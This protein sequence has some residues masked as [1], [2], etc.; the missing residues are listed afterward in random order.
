[1]EA[2][3]NEEALLMAMFN[4][5]VTPRNT[6]F[7][8]WFWQQVTNPDLPPPEIVSID[9]DP[10]Y[11]EDDANFLKTVRKDGRIS[12]KVKKG[13]REA[14]AI[15]AIIKAICKVTS[16]SRLEL[17]Y[18]SK[19]K[20]LPT[21]IGNLTNLTL[22]KIWNCEKLN[23][24][25]ES[26]G[27]LVNLTNLDI[28]HCTELKQLPASIS[29]LVNIQVLKI[30]GNSLESLPDTFGNL[31]PNA[32]SSLETLYMGRNQ[33]AT[34]PDSFCLLPNL[35]ELG[36][37]GPREGVKLQSLPA[38]FGNLQNLHFF[39]ISNNELT[40]LP[41]SFKNIPLYQL[42]ISDNNISELPPS[43]VNPDETILDELNELTEFNMENNPIDETNPNINERIQ[44]R[45]AL[46]IAPPQEEVP[47]PAR[48]GV[49]FE[50][51]N[52]FN[53]INK[54]K[55]INFLK[56]PAN[57]VPVFQSN[58]DFIDYF[59]A[60]LKDFLALLPNNANK[61]NI[62][63]DYNKIFDERLSLINYHSQ[64]ETDYKPLITNALEY[65]KR[66][67]DDFKKRYGFSF[68]YDNA[69]AYEGEHP[70]SCAKG[71]IERFITTLGNV[72]GQI[73]LADADEF[74]AKNYEELLDIMEPKSLQQYVNMYMSECFN[75]D[76]INSQ[77]TKAKK[78]EALEMCIRAKLEE[79]FEGQ[80]VPAAAEG[81]I[82]IGLEEAGN[83]INDNNTSGGKRRTGRAKTGKAKTGR[84]KTKR[85]SYRFRKTQK[86]NK[87]K[88][89]Y[90]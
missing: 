73:K 27:N 85:R 62:M 77:P 18:I 42:N 20:K 4:P 61:D 70:L 23:E 76:D 84:A 31:I 11:G 55:L 52:A 29:N 21:E 75:S 87:N 5:Q 3:T 32:F 13:E 79:H 54:Q 50:V 83:M 57:P 8:E 26:I 56:D 40:T 34:L 43:S 28:I 2:P 60:T 15:N 65:A 35:S 80:I 36:L 25:P 68:T 48:A 39:D 59:D 67:S 33:L 45:I 30:F 63:T 64:G 74:E 51:H 81:L 9:F 14:D 69:H 86:K 82:A 88:N 90:F 19:L 47:Q 78:I 66:Q 71:M 12:T 22:L 58:D 17:L 24:I 10:L 1:M 7:K 41:E 89:K 16:I 6:E 38:N 37:E 49:A 46:R 72:A 53:N 44:A